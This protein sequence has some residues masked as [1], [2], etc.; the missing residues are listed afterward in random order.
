MKRRTLL[1]TATLLS[2]PALAQGIRIVR[3]TTPTTTTSTTTT[4]QVPAGWHVVTGRVRAPRDV[5]LPAG[6][7]VTISL[8]DVTREDEP[9]TTVLKVDFPTSRLSTPYQLQFNPVRLSEDRTYIVT[10]RIY[11]ASG[12]LL[13]ISRTRQELPSA[14]NVIM[15][16]NVVAAR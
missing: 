8:E 5:R 3:P 11:N 15:D 12:R 14:K 6:S 10:A 16:L 9:S 2:T 13:Y 4:V 1:L 7:T